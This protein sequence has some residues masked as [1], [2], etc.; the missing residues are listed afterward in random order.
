MTD[1]KEAKVRRPV[2]AR[3]AAPGLPQSLP[4][5]V[6]SAAASPGSRQRFAG[7][8]GV[9]DIGS[10]SIRLV[11]FER[12]GRMPVPVFNERVICGLGKGLADSGRLSEEGKVAAVATL[13]RFA[14]LAEAMQVSA[15]EFLATAAVRDAADGAAF[16][17]EVEALCGYPVRILD[18]EQEATLAA[19]GVVVG[20]PQ[21]DGLVGDLGGGSLE[22]IELD[23]GALGRRTT[24][25]LGPLRLIDASSGDR[26]AA[27][28]LVGEALASVPWLD[29]MR[30]RNFYA[31][32]GAWRNLA[33]VHMEQ[34]VY[35]LHV[36]QHYTANASAVAELSRVI[37]QQGKRSL[38][39]IPAVSRRRVE[40]LPFAALAFAGVLERVAPMSVI[41]S[42]YGLREGLLFEGLSERERAKDPLAAIAEDLERREGRFPRLG[43]TL[44]QWLTPVYFDLRGLERRLLHAAAHL[45]DVAWRDHPDYRAAQAFSRLLFYPYAG[46]DHPGRA[47]LALSAYVRYGGGFEDDVTAPA[48]ALLSAVARHEAR[49][50]GLGI[51]LAYS[52]CG[53]APP[54]LARTRLSV[55]G[56][57]LRLTLPPDGS[58][59]PGGALSRRHEALAC[60]MGLD[61]TQVVFDA[62]D[63]PLSTAP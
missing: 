24:L 18:G 39:K 37:A 38:S 14:R 20:I 22:L 62:S 36:I 16:V 17:A 26:K 13:V 52:V 43:R 31:V 27:D 29:E 3:I 28:A 56:R 50:L 33:R 9:V 59:P 32:G 25:P 34:I 10:N 21:A 15:L 44:L 11:V 55:V 30:G 2:R 49:L 63:A 48:R 51:R 35:P 54:V 41:F 46:L 45:G 8:V 47:F 19:Y 58:P 60:A 53:G 12:P 6:G 40:T 5:Q 4:S 42:A 61:G 1:S 57:S 7:R 23:K